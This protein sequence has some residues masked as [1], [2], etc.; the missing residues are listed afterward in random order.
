MTSTFRSPVVARRLTRRATTGCLLLLM[1][2]AVLLVYFW[3]SVWRMDHVN[4]ERKR[5]A[6]TS[7]LAQAQQV[8]HTTAAGLNSAHTTDPD[9][10]TSVIWR[11]THAPIITYDP[12]QHT[13]TAMASWTVTYT[14][15][16]L[17]PGSGPIRVERCFT[18]T[19][20]QTSS[21]LW[22][23]KLAE[24]SDDTCSLSR[25]LA[26]DVSFAKDRMMSMTAETVTRVDVAQALDPTHKLRVYSVKKVTRSDGVVHINVLVS[27]QRHD[28]SAHQCYAFTRRSGP[29]PDTRSVTAVP[30]ATC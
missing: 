11:H 12:A 18:L 19:S 26:A 6:M 20:A 22:A 4:A 7:V 15:K 24:G 3:Y 27:D 23:T 9:A 16:A 29:N 14:E 25:K 5:V 13:Y 8:S 10:L 28:T 17:L 1:V 21:A 2:P 30:L